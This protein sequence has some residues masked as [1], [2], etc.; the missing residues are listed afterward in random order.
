MTQGSGRGPLRRATSYAAGSVLLAFSL[1]LGA[2][3][4]VAAGGAGSDP[5]A[6]TPEQVAAQV[7]S[8][9]QVQAQINAASPTVAAA[10]ANLAAL[11]QR[12]ALYLERLDEAQSAQASAVAAK[13]AADGQLARLRSDLANRQAE[14]GDWARETYQQ[15]D[16]RLRQLSAFADVLTSPDPAKGADLMGLLQYLADERTLRFDNLENAAARQA[17]ASAKA[18]AAEREATAAAAD[19]SAARAALDGLVAQQ[20]AAL[21]A[22]QAAESAVP[23][24]ATLSGLLRTSTSGADQQL[25]DALQAIPL[26]VTGTCQADDGVYP[27]GQLPASALCPLYKAPGQYLREDP[28]RAFNALSRA[29]EQATGRPIC[30]TDSYRTLAGQYSVYARKPTLAAKPGTS[31]HGLGR[32][33]D[34]CGGV[35]SFGDPAHLWMKQNAPLFGWY[36]PAWAE[37]TGS[38]PE[39]W[40]WEYAG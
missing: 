8:G 27:N 14:I 13:A 4:A 22:L 10:T 15:G 26:P 1:L 33:V 36:H 30:V 7:R 3:A 24:A 18:A 5:E 6:L 11:S 19:A 23:A 16:G 37:P 31:K 34:M 20:K 39:P 9:Q 38:K 21:A 35:Q 32:A 17:E 2:Q 12:A 25:L 29:Y 28:A 40:H